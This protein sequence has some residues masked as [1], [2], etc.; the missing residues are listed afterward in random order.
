MMH[1]IASLPAFGPQS[2]ADRHPRIAPF[3]TWSQCLS[4]GVATLWIASSAALH[5]AETAE[6]NRSNSI[7][8]ASANPHLKTLGVKEC[9][10]CHSQPG[11]LYPKLNVTQFVHL[12]EAVQ[13]NTQDKHA[14]AYELVRVD[15]KPAEWDLPERASNRRVRTMIEKL[16]WK[17]GDG[18]FERKCLTCHAGTTPDQDFKDPISLANLEFGVQCESCHGPGEKYLATTEHQQP[19]WRTKTPEQKAALGMT[20]LSNAAVVAEVCLSCHLGN[21]KAGRFVTHDMYAAG[22]PPLPPFELQTFLDAMPPHWGTIAQKPYATTLTAD[23]AAEFENQRAYLLNH[24][25]LDPDKTT[26]QMQSEVQ[27]SFERTK[28][29]MVGAM[30]AQDASLRLIHDSA[31]QPA[32]WGDYSLFDCMGCHQTLYKDRSRNR[33]AGRI[34]GRPFPS[35]WTS[36]SDAISS[37]AL[38]AA[39]I[40]SKLDEAFNEVPFGDREKVQADQQLYQNFL[41]ARRQQWVSWSQELLDA[42]ATREWIDRWIDEQSPKL[43]DYWVAKQTAWLVSIAIR[44]LIEKKQLDPAAVAQDLESLD[45][46]LGLQLQVPQKQ[47]VLVNQSSTL[48]LAQTFDVDA[49]REHLM[50]LRQAIRP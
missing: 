6:P 12:T 33:P 14:Y 32:N 16:G 41:A 42:E 4:I 37:D 20:D 10:A 19:T 50:R 15:L 43:T 29:S 46:L 17:V 7:L 47:S 1:A 22:H 18:N 2:S 44:E 25:K 21:L 13:W 39:P 27:Q 23:R 8:Q 9:A 11:F 36:L 31:E 34:P 28:R 26:A 30:A 24:F 5:A 48:E 45:R 40:Q 3:R 35:N 49:V 38:I